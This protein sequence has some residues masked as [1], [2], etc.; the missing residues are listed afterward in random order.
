MLGTS[1]FASPGLLPPP[2]PTSSL[3]LLHRLPPPPLPLD[4]A[5]RRRH[6]ES[7]KGNAE[8]ETRNQEA[9]EHADEVDME[10]QGA[11]A[12]VGKEDAEDATAG[13]NVA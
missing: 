7:A 8:E 10:W 6:H 12:R 1:S 2:P 3:A 4:H 13:K 9:D 5:L 11:R